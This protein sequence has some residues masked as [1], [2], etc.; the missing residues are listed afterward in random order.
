[1]CRF[2]EVSMFPFYPA[3]LFGSQAAKSQ[4]GQVM[5]GYPCLP[6]GERYSLVRSPPHAGG[7]HSI[8]TL[9]VWMPSARRTAG[10]ASR[11]PA[12]PH[13]LP[14]P[15]CPAISRHTQD[16]HRS[17]RA[18]KVL[19]LKAHRTLGNAYGYSAEWPARSLRR[20]VRGAPQA[21]LD[22]ASESSHPPAHVPRHVSLRADHGY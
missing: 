3:G 20:F 1:M 19:L 14:M 5:N 12:A 4:P 9:Y 21:V 7:P 2:L 16:I 17:G 11:V 8:R 10:G 6:G 15:L 22:R 18:G 13:A